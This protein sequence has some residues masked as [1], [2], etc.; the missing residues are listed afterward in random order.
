M[1]LDLT[2]FVWRAKSSSQ[3]F[4][5]RL[6]FFFW[7]ILQIPTT[8]SFNSLVPLGRLLRRMRIKSNSKSTGHPI[9][10]WVM[11]D[12]GWNKRVCMEIRGLTLIWLNPFNT[13]VIYQVKTLEHS[14][15][16]FFLILELWGHWSEFGKS[17]S[18]GVV[19]RD[20]VGNFGRFDDKTFS[21]LLGRVVQS[22]I[23]LTQD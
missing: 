9:V 8:L 11:E 14:V 6:D 10:M 18:Y 16:S 7:K 3:G 23:K 21:K 12:Y 13:C 17:V 22:P 15:V 2:D 20:K 1:D 5:I 19:K 4:Q